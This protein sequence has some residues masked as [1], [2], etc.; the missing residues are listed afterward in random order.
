[1]Q[2]GRW[3][4]RLAEHRRWTPLADPPALGQI[5]AALSGQAPPETVLAD[6]LA[7]CAD[8]APARRRAEPAAPA[9][10]AL[11]RVAAAAQD[12]ADWEQRPPARADRLPTAALFLAACLWR[13]HGT[14]PTTA[15]PLWSATPRRLDALALTTG[16]AWIAGVLAAVAEAA[17]RAGQELSRLQAAAGRAAA[18]RRTAR[19]HLPEAAALALREPVLTAAGLAAGLRI[20]HQ[21]ALGLLRDLVAAGV[22]QEATGRT[23]W[24]AFGVA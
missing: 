5:L 18:L 22:L 8:P 6:W 17:Q 9:V 13:R 1:L 19:S 23:T 21:A 10:P 15:L 11:L 12:W 16:P 3:W 7:R 20:S 2:L 4:R 14:T 24:R